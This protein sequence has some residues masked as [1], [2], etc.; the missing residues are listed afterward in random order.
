[1]NAPDI[2]LAPPDAVEAVAARAETEIFNI[3]AAI[4]DL[5]ADLWRILP[6][7][8][9]ALPALVGPAVM[10]AAAVILT[11]AAARLLLR[12]QRCRTGVGSNALV[13]LLKLTGL[14]LLALASAALVGRVLLVRVFGIPHGAEGLAVDLTFAVLRWLMGVT[15]T[16]ILFQPAAPRF[17]LVAVDDA[18]ARKAARR[19][20]LIL[21]VGYLHIALLDAAQC[22]GLPIVS[23]KLISCLVGLG[24]VAG[25]VRLIMALRRNGMTRA[26]RLMAIGLALVTCLLWFWGWITLDFEPYRGA[27]DT[28]AALLAAGALDRAVVL[29]IRD[30]QKPDVMRMLSVLRA[31]VAALAVALMMRIVVD[32]WMTDAFGWLSPEQG[33]VLSPRLTLAS[34]MIVSAAVLAAIVHTATEAWSTP[35][36]AATT[37]DREADL[38]RLSTALS[39][40]RFSALALIGVVFSLL[41]LSALGVDVTALLVGAA[42]VGSAI[43]FG[44]QT[45]VKDVVTGLFFAIDDAFRLGET[46]EFGGKHCQLE[47][48]NLRSLRLRDEDGRLHTIAFG[49]LGIATNHSRRRVRMTALMTLK[50]VPAKSELVRLSRDAAAALRGEP[51]ISRAIIGS[52]GVRL[53]EAP[54]AS[55]ATLALSFT[56][57]ALAA[58]RTRLLV[59]RLFEETV[60]VAGIEALLPSVRVTVSDISSLSPSLQPDTPSELA[61]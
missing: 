19:I 20:A 41:A 47:R 52:I 3:V 36:P 46:I 21:A 4:A 31:I 16:I 29:G 6:D 15:L 43:S 61:P 58:D 51:M 13:G 8:F 38:A 59:Q 60:Y 5:P 44:L 37:M 22:Y 30:S 34:A 39:V 24:M 53:N 35:D 26:P 9:D 27:V 23:V 50:S 28:I 32:V 18:G 56:I 57:A 11:F 12:S 10:V 17:R 25:A 55:P 1:M 33:R 7:G 45:L 48:I 49:E 54:D 14:E 2:A 40:I 42:M